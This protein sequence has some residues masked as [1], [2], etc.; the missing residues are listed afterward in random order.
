MTISCTVNLHVIILIAIGWNEINSH[1]IAF[2]RFTNQL[3]REETWRSTCNWWSISVSGSFMVWPCVLKLS[4]EKNG[5]KKASASSGSETLT[6]S[7]P[8][9]SWMSDPIIQYSTLCCFFSPQ[10][11]GHPGH[12]S[13]VTGVSDALRRSIMPTLKRRGRSYMKTR[14]DGS[15]AHGAGAAADNLKWGKKSDRMSRLPMKIEYE[16]RRRSTKT[17][18]RTTFP[19]IVLFSSSSSSFQIFSALNAIFFCYCCFNYGFCSSFFLLSVAVF[20]FNV[21][22]TILETTK[23]HFFQT[24]LAYVVFVILFNIIGMEINSNY[25]FSYNYY[26]FLLMES[27]KIFYID[28]L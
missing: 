14:R 7:P 13:T 28:Y 22:Q 9:T 4:E 15:G 17:I 27:E 16:R 20:I 2:E 23:M 26:S 25:P 18:V 1:R 8:S 5:T 19:Y 6:T 10:F 3:Q 12:S 21:F 11:S 24:E